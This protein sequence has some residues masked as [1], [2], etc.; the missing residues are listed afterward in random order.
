[1]IKYKIK[2]GIN[3]YHIRSSKFK[4]VTAS[5]NIHRPLLK[6]EASMNALL[7]DVM[8]R[9]NKTHPDMIAISKELQS[10]Y[11][12]GFYTNIKRK[13]EDQ[14]VS[15]SVSAVNDKYVGDNCS[16]KAISFMYDVLLNPLKENGG[17]KNDYVEQEK[18]NLKNDILALINDK[19]SY[20]SWRILEL[21][22]SDD[23]YSVHELGTIEDVDKITN[24]SLFEH[25][26]KILKESPIDIFITGDIDI[27]KVIALT[28]DAFKDIHP[29]NFVYPACSLY[30]KKAL[31]NITETFDVTQAKLCLGF[32]TNILPTDEDYNALMVYN[33]IL[34]GGPHSK[35]FNNV[36]EKLSLAYYVSSRLE[37]YKGLMTIS[38]GIETQN[39][40]AAM[41]EIYVQMDAMKKGDISDYEFDSTIKSITNS[42][43]SFG[44]DVGYSEDYYL[45]QLVT[46]NVVPINELIKNI[47]AVTKE[48]VYKVAQKIEP[49]MV[50]FL[51][52]ESEGK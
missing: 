25:Y 4:T 22:C 43:K 6:S 33:G 52:S 5:V 27:K 14:I 44:D 26:E 15:F 39:K 49:Q 48:D 21:M 41:D 10:L 42:L 45:G 36:R 2:D 23:S 24:V 28:E 13:G 1:M 30:N 19:R 40:D 31:D 37:R 3:L 46:G 18:V 51:T 50:Y 16:E 32:A 9:G 12:A 35:L 34:G 20:A 47:E 11:G 38:S 8:H 7:T 29:E 17:F